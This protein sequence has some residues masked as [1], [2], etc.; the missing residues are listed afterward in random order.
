MKKRITIFAILAASV[1]IG[2]PT[3]GLGSTTAKTNSMTGGD[4]A[5]QIRVTIGQPR[6]RWRRGYYRDGRSYRNYG[7]YRRSMVGNRRFRM[8]P[9]YYWDD[10]R[11]RVRY[12]RFY[13]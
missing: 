12:V 11:R 5:A 8:V 2:L 4:P 6:R 7:M 1:F 10:G 13:D 9:R 3:D